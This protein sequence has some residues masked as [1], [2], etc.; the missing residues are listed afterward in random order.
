VK[1]TYS[2]YKL[3]L[4]EKRDCVI[5]SY[6]FLFIVSYIFYHS[7][8]VSLAFGAFIPICFKY[9]AENLAE[10]RRDLMLVQFR[11]FLYSLSA[12]FAAGRHMREA[13]FEAR[14]SL[15]LIYDE[16]TPMLIEITNMLSKMDGGKASEEDVLRDFADRSAMRDIANFVDTYFICRETGGYLGRVISKTSAMLIDKIGIEKEVKTLTSQKQFEGRIISLMPVA[17][18]LFL[19]VVSPEYIQILYTTLAGRFIMTVA[20][21]GIVYAYEMTMKL[22]KIEV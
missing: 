9:Y 17:V 1:T 5:V 20:L 2:K 21:A 15:R 4:K 8:A 12:S 14:E 18:I 3:T 7:L 19:N 22:T 10:K 13:L 16:N 11:D 6:V